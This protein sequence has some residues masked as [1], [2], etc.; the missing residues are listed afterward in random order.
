MDCLIKTFNTLRKVIEEKR[1]EMYVKE[2]HY[3]LKRGLIRVDFGIYKLTIRQYCFEDYAIV[4]HDDKEYVKWDNAPHHRHVSTYPH[5]M[6]NENGNVRESQIAWR[7]ETLEKDLMYILNTIIN[8]YIKLARK[9][10]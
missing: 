5:H 3:D 9:T 1:Y 8:R 6:H 7:E 10:S 4:L 2:L